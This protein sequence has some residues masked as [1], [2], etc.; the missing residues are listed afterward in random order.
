MPCCGYNNKAK[1]V[2]LIELLGFIGLLGFVELLELIYVEEKDSPS[3]KKLMGYLRFDN[4][5]NST[6]PTNP[7]TAAPRQ[8][9]L[10][11][12][13]SIHSPGLILEGYSLLRH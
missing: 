8:S 7:I 6:N 4:S 9:L 1:G 11:P 12:Q 5:I 13:S 2:G 3:A 10:L